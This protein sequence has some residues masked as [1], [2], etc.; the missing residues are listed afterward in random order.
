MSILI[1]IYYLSI[2]GYTLNIPP[3]LLYDKTKEVVLSD[4]IHKDRI[5]K[6]LSEVIEINSLPKSINDNVS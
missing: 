2:N 3:L 6:E 5:I 1:T 4:K